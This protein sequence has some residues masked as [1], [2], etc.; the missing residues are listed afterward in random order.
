MSTTPLVPK[1]LADWIAQLQSLGASFEPLNNNSILTDAT[2]A[3]SNPSIENPVEGFGRVRGVRV[4]LSTIT[5][6]LARATA[7]RGLAAARARSEV[8]AN[9]ASFVAVTLRSRTR[10]S[11]TS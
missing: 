1:Q 2:S 7:R 5:Y 8:E 10:P 4:C 11:W 6:W 3:S 9:S